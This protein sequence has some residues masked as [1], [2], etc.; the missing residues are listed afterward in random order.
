MKNL[1]FQGYAQRK[2]FNPEKVPDETFK[3]RQE[4]ERQLQGMR[5]VRDQN[6]QNR[7]EQLDALKTNAYKEQQQ[8]NQNFD[9]ASNFKKA[10]HD[11]EMQHY[12]TYLQ[13]AKTKEIEAR[14][15]ADRF[16]KLKDLA[17]KAFKSLIQLQGQRLENAL[18]EATTRFKNF[19]AGL[20]D[21]FK[22]QE[23]LHNSFLK[24]EH[25]KYGFLDTFTDPATQLH[26]HRS[27]KGLNGIA[28]Q[29]KMLSDYGKHGFLT[30]LKNQQATLK[31][32]GTNT[33]NQLAADPNDTDGTQLNAALTN[34]YNGALRKL[35]KGEGNAGYSSW[36]VNKFFTPHADAIIA[37]ERQA[38]NDLVINNTKRI[39]AEKDAT[40]YNHFV[41]SENGTF[42]PEN[43]PKFLELG[44]NR[45]V[46][47]ATAHHQN[48][49]QLQ[50]GEMTEAEIDSLHNVEIDFNGKKMFLGDLWEPEFKEYRKIIETRK[51]KEREL[52]DTENKNT[53]SK[54]YQKLKDTEKSTGQRANSATFKELYDGMKMEG[55]TDFEIKKYAPWYKDMQNREP[56]D[57]A[58]SRQIADGLYNDG[59]L[60]V[61]ALIHGVD[62]RLWAEYLPKTI[63]AY[64]ITKESI[65]KR[66]SN[67]KKAIADATGQLIKDPSARSTTVDQMYDI[68]KRKFF[69]K[70]LKVIADGDI[71]GAENALDYALNE[72]IKLIEARQGIYALKVDANGAPLYGD[73]AGFKY[74]QDLTKDPE[75]I[76]IE[77]G[78]LSDQNAAQKP[79][80]FGSDEEAVLAW[81]RGEGPMPTSL[82]VAFKA[83]KYKSHK[84]IVNDVLISRG[85]KPLEYVGLEQAQTW[86]NGSHLS[87]I[88]NAPSIFKYINAVTVSAS[89]NNDYTDLT[90]RLTDTLIPKDIYNF[91][92]DNPSDVA[93]NAEGLFV[94]TEE[95]GRPLEEF[96]LSDVKT[97]FG[98]N[99]L[100]NVG[101]FDFDKETLE[102]EE[103][104]GN[105]DEDT[106]LTPDLMR[107][108]KMQ[109][110]YDESSKWYIS[111]MK[112]AIPGFGKQ[113]AQPIKKP[114]RTI[115]TK[116]ERE[117]SIQNNLQS[118]SKFIDSYFESEVEREAFKTQQVQ[119]FI[120]RVRSAVKKGI[121]EG[122][123]GTS[124]RRKQLKQKMLENELS[125]T[126][127]GY[128]FAE[129]GIEFGRLTDN[130]K[131]TILLGF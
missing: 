122:T 73:K 79:G 124:K 130:T 22:V 120:D 28:I 110:I 123:A 106:F 115:K 23:I 34:I 63:D 111:G 27:F 102:R 60:S 1:S 86:V 114:R 31:I 116:E 4:T 94:F 76:R 58:K 47:K 26:I 119:S 41:R 93:K 48:V 5:A 15:G 55:M 17:P 104:K 6:R 69:P 49:Q 66:A 59:L 13:D 11:A 40:T 8:R 99:Q 80:F 57:L 117:L 96:T 78:M 127:A 44:K 88:N 90:K 51:T 108:L 54:Y 126:S 50:S 21:Q 125:Q 118:I 24:G 32:D 2:G 95:F 30:E 19:E 16:D 67:L 100:V 29:A 10:F 84:D 98:T 68:A 20:P 39:N 101:P 46:R 131:E 18:G 56:I 43:V 97:L 91:H 81:G 82:S 7:N 45:S 14:R 85:E 12:E 129:Y 105:I 75:L 42:I 62:P 3:I 128:V 64:G 38:V 37:Q 35:G 109:N 53:S 113:H 103:A 71:K 36:L 112:E 89:E 25:P 92:P 9:L 52:R 77:D 65:D 121:N 83:S 61:D 74:F 72:E 107:Y 87:D 70:A 33:Y